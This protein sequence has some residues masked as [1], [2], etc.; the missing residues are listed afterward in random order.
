M[1]NTRIEV[2]GLKE[3]ARA[4]EEFGHSWPKATAKFLYQEMEIEMAES[5]QIVPLDEGP[6]RASGS[7]EPPVITPTEVVV[8]LGYGGPAAPYA[9]KQHE[10]PDLIHP[11]GREW[12]YLE[13]PL[14]ESAPH[15]PDRIGRRLLNWLREWSAVLTSNGK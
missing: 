1:K 8:E 10:D 6:L 7:V 9:I 4:I 11:N 12:K 3:A 14:M 15:L 2:T 5:K 13:R